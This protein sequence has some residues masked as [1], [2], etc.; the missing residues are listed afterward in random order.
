MSLK[1]NPRYELG[2]H[3][4]NELCVILSH[5]IAGIAASLTLTNQEHTKQRKINT[6]RYHS[7]AQKHQTDQ[8]GK[9]KRRISNKERSDYHRNE[10]RWEIELK[11]IGFT[12]RNSRESADGE[13]FWVRLDHLSLLGSLCSFLSI[14]FFLFNWFNRPENWANWRVESCHVGC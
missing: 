11:S 7:K 4:T 12:G 2:F 1:K 9:Q 6:A 13:R 10:T 14:F 3:K 5:Q 8:S